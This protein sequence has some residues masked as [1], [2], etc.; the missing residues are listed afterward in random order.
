[1]AQ[2]RASHH[3]PAIE[4]AT[5]KVTVRNER[6]RRA[7]MLPTGVQFQIQERSTAEPCLGREGGG[8]MRGMWH[9]VN[10]LTPASV[11]DGGCN[12]GSVELSADS[13]P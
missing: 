3:G 4:S 8:I 7:A 6:E 13:R 9:L 5:F 10:D 12:M 2:Y 11:A 1:M